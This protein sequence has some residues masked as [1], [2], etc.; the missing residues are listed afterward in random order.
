MTKKQE[1]KK[2]EDIV[3]EI[4]ETKLKTESTIFNKSSQT[5][6]NRL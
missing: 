4:G 1:I 6:R 5:T 2:R 3:T